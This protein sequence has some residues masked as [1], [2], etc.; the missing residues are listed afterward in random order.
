[1][2]ASQAL[3]KEWLRAGLSTEPADR[4]LALAAL[5]KHYVALGAPPPSVAVWMSSPLEGV[6][7]A[8]ILSAAFGKA[9]S[10]L[11]SHPL[12]QVYHRVLAAH[13]GLDPS[14]VLARAKGSD[15][16]LDAVSRVRR[17]VEETVLEEAADPAT[18]RIRSVLWDRVMLQLEAQL[19]G[20]IGPGAWARL[21]RSAGSEPC[22]M[23]LIEL[24]NWICWAGYGQHDAELLGMYARCGLEGTDIGPLIQLMQLGRTCGWWW[25]FDGAC[26][27]TE[28]PTTLELNEQLLCQSPTGKALDY[29]DR[30]GFHAWKGVRVPARVAIYPESLN[31]SVVLAEPRAK[32]REA[33]VDRVD[34]ATLSTDW[35]SREPDAQVRTA[36]VRRMDP[37]RVVPELLSTEI[38]PMVRLAI[39]QR[40]DP[41][42]LSVDL[43]VGEWDVEVRRAV[44]ERIGMDRLMA[45]DGV[46]VVHQDAGRLLL[47]FELQGDEPLVVVRVACPSTGRLYHLRVPPT[48]ATCQQAVAW[49]FGLEADQYAPTT[50][51]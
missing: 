6:I 9:V 3:I 2:T 13:R 47:R 50:E 48:I 5:R 46:R 8:R 32:I 25:G 34:P 16:P 35:L 28:R 31:G 4:P 7:A 17:L 23:S 11:R 45:T 30:F 26:V 44:L 39:V 29:P 49:T 20:Q 33:M 36:M 42:S 37:A 24:T 18:R 22:A 10:E 41:D 21:Q 40:L 51:S 43:F 27:L 1:M 14:A 12:T 38:S 19:V 15:W